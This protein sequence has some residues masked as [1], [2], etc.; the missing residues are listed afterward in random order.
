MEP[1]QLVL[2]SAGEVVCRVDM[3]VVWLPCSFASACLI[4]G[5]DYELNDADDIASHGPERAEDNT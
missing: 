2:R 5:I 3:E 4:E 1:V